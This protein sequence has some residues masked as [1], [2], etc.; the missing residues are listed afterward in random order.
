MPAGT[1]LDVLPAGGT[2]PVTGYS[3]LE[4]RPAEYVTAHCGGQ[5]GTRLLDLG[6]TVQADGAVRGQIS[7]RCYSLHPGERAGGR[8]SEVHNLFL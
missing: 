8:L 5:E 4:T 7:R 6:Q 3:R 2:L 1:G